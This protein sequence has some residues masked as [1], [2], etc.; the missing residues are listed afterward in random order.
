MDPAI[1]LQGEGNAFSLCTF[2]GRDVAHRGIFKF[3][4]NVLGTNHATQYLTFS[5]EG[6]RAS[7]EP[8]MENGG[9]LTAPIFNDLRASVY[10]LHMA[11]QSLQ[12]DT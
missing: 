1:A 3:I 8:G 2:N 12:G 6:V 11:S 10:H 9:D 4:Y 5:C 7:N